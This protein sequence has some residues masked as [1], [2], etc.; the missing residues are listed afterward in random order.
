MPTGKYPRK[1]YDRTLRPI[2]RD[3][4]SCYVT[5]P[6][7]LMDELGWKPGNRVHFSITPYG[8]QME[9][10]RNEKAISK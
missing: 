8:L 9:F 7:D 5:V 6:L 2:E 3:S 1:F 4:R 10:I